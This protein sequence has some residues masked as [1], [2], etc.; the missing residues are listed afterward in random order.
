[1]N[2]PRIA[3]KPERAMRKRPASPHK[4]TR[5]QRQPPMTVAK[6]ALKSVPASK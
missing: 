4:S 1:M 3:K 2:P 6:H 5:P